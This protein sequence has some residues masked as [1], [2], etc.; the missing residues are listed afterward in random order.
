MSRARFTLGG[1]LIGFVVAYGIGRA[2]PPMVLVPMLFVGA[3][4][5]FMRQIVPLGTERSNTRG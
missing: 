5:V 2:L 4:M 1:A 3:A